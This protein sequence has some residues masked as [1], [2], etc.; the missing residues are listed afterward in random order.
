[1]A[2]SAPK[3]IFVIPDAQVRPGV[4]LD[5]I[6][7]VGKS[8]VEYRPDIIVCLGDFCDMHSLSS[9]EE[10]GSAP[11]EGARYKDDIFTANEAFRRLCIPMEKELARIKRRHIKKWTPRLV[12]LK[13]NHEIRA[14]RF[15]E[16]DPRYLGVLSSDDFETPGWE[17]Y[18]FLDIVEIEGVLFSHYFK[19][20]NSNNPI[21]GSTDNRLNKIG[22]SHVQGH[23]VGFI[24]GNRVYP[25]G[26]TRHSL[27]C[28]SMYLHQEEFRGPQCNTH[29]RGVVLLND[30]R[31]GDF[32][33]MPLSL[34]HLCRKH[35]GEEL[36]EYMRKRYIH[37]D[38]EYLA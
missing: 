29:F 23:Q 6:D 8:I 32:D 16:N 4:P 15:V 22:R 20:Q 19:M 5:Y 1:M 17:R 2:A 28:G 27:T 31:D 33:V 30:V 13:G 26:S 7:W 3:R 36:V 9:Y 25:D 10:K 38:W 37:G 11:M 14:D 35:T 12:Y 24:Y 34:R 21:G 18:G